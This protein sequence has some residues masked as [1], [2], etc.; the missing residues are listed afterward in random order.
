MLLLEEP[1]W[2]GRGEGARIG[3]MVTIEMTRSLPFVL[4]SYPSTQE[5]QR[6][7]HLVE[8]PSE[9]WLPSDIAVFVSQSREP[10]TAQGVTKVGLG[11]DKMIKYI[12]SEI[13]HVQNQ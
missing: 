4:G 1:K 13:K 11:Q 8:V 12:N 6:L 9:D 7:L 10:G 2:F 3:R 5:A